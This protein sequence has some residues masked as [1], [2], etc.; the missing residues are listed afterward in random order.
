VCNAIASGDLKAQLAFVFLSREPGEAPQTDRFIEQVSSYNIPLEYLSYQKYKARHGTTEEEAADILPQ[1]RLGYDRRMMKL[2]DGYQTDICVLAGFMLIVGAEVCTTYKMINL[3]PAAPGGPAGTWREVIWR[4]IDIE[5][6]ETGVMMHLVTPQLDK[7]PVATYTTFSI[8]GEPF[9]SLWQHVAG[10]TSAHIK[11][12][13]GENNALF[14]LI[15][16]YGMARELPLLIATL[17]AFS[18]GRVKLVNGFVLDKQGKP[19][20]GYNLT[21]EIEQRLK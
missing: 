13:E 5:A 10:R 16:Q 2:L 8:R 7:G 4:L 6:R 1:W 15:R 21:D 17:K 18:Q 14:K 19:V 9:D 12:T 20:N 3:H 11:A